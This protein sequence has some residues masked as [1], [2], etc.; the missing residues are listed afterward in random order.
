VR[1][2]GEQDFTVYKY[3][4]LVAKDAIVRDYKMIE[5]LRVTYKGGR[6]NN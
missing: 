5:R 4:S 6:I 1:A 3:S 2:A